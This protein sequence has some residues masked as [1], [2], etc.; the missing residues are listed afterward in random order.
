MSAS[1]NFAS[2]L[3]SPLS[4]VSI[5]RLLPEKYIFPES[6]I[7]Y[8]FKPSFVS[9]EILAVGFSPHALHT[10]A[11]ANTGRMVLMVFILLI[12]KLVSYCR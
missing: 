7:S 6:Y 1:L 11:S 3:F 8:V 10:R 9:T 5:T 12:T 2:C 4:D